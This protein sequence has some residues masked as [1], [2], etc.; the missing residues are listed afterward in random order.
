MNED[1]AG[2]MAK[3][4]LKLFFKIMLGMNLTPLR[5]FI[6]KETA[7]GDTPAAFA[8]TSGNL[9]GVS[10]VSLIFPPSFQSVKIPW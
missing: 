3:Q 8:E 7:V 10:G 5:P 6:T 2:F 1:E 4:M 9:T